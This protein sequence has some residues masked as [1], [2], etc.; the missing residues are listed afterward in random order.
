MKPELHLFKTI[1]YPKSQALFIAHVNF[2][3]VF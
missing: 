1:E 3:E 2:I